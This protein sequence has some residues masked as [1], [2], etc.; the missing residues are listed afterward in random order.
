MRAPIPRRQAAKTKPTWWPRG[1]EPIPGCLTLAIGLCCSPGEQAY[2]R[3]LPARIQ[4][5]RRLLVLRRMQA[6]GWRR[7]YAGVVN[8]SPRG[9][10]AAISSTIH[11]FEPGQCT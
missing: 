10:A 8:R 6:P 7:I 5:F 2:I 4:M 1:G 3:R 11:Q 9:R